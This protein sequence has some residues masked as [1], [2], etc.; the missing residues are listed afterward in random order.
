[1]PRRSGV[2]LAR[3]ARGMRPELPVIICTGLITDAL[4]LDAA[5]IGVTRLLYKPDMPR[6]I[7]QIAQDLFS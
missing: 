4:A 3:D 1:M 7:R 5:S 2:E 6:Q